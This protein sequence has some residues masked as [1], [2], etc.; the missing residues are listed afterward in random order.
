M[1]SFSRILLARVATLILWL[2]FAAATPVNG[3]A[4]SKAE[5]LSLYSGMPTSEVLRRASD[6]DTY[7]LLEMGNRYAAGSSGVPQNPSE[8]ARLYSL[9]YQ[10]GYPGGNS[11]GRLPLHP[12][13]FLQVV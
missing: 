8:A 12:I 2:S 9:T 13:P 6:G 4:L 1:S 3:Q 7:A 5:F 10:R 11:V